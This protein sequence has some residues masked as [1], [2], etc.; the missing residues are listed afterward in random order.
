MSKTVYN[1]YFTK[2]GDE[3][4]IVTTP[5]EKLAQAFWKQEYYP[6][7]DMQPSGV[8][9]TTMSEAALEAAMAKKTLSQDKETGKIRLLVEK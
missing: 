2:Y 1:V 3:R 7:L 9:K 8:K 6:Y 4:V 5:D